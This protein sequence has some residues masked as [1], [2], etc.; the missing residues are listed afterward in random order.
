MEKYEGL[1]EIV[2]DTET[3]GL[4][5]TSGHKLVEIGCVELINH[6]PTGRVWQTYFNPE[7]D[8]PLEA[9]RVHGLSREF[10]RDK[11]F[12]KEKT[13]EFLNFIGTS[14]LIIHNAPFD[15]GFI[16]HELSLLS[17]KVLRCHV[18]NDFVPRNAPG[19][20]IKVIDTL[21]LARKKFPGAPNSLDAL[22]KRLKVDNTMRDKHG[23]LMDAELLAKVYIELL[24]GRQKVLELQL[25]KDK[26]EASSAGRDNIDG[27]LTNYSKLVV[28]P[29]KEEF[30]L[31]EKAMKDILG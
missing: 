10:L 21:T 4:D 17:L 15:I 9:Y 1:R 29:D 18:K 27:K 8:M 12:F 26:K 31:H 6:V 24:G 25:D 19:V 2:L 28:K 5:P 7:R 16:N 14:T 11:P 30:A 3:T 23:A 22:C 20:K 13:E